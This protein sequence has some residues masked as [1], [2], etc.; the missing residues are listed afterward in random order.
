MRVLL[1]S[2]R[3]ANPGGTERYLDTLATTLR[4]GGDEVRILAG[5]PAGV[6][7]PRRPGTVASL[8]VPDVTVADPPPL[9]LRALT[10]V[11]N[12]AALRAIGAMLADFRPAAVHVA[13]LLSH[14]SPAILQPLRGTATSVIAT[15]LRFACPLGTKLLPDGRQCRRPAGAAC[16][17]DGCLSP[18][19]A[20]RDG[21][22]QALLRSGLH[23]VRGMLACSNHLVAEL[24]TVGIDSRVVPLPVAAPR[25]APRRVPSRAPSFVFAGR[26]AAVKGLDQLIDAFADLQSTSPDARLL[27][28]G[29]GPERNRLRERIRRLRLADAVRMA[30]EMALDWSDSLV[31]ATALVA[32]SLYREPLGLSVIEA[33]L[34]GTP[35]IASRL[36]GHGE[37]VE[38]GVSGLLVDN[39]DPR[40][41]AAA[42]RGLCGESPAVPP[43]VPED[44]RGRL[45]RRH[46]PVHHRET[47]REIWAGKG[48][49][50]R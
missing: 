36:G 28:C 23:R 7:P 31:T 4:A 48:G 10:Q 33:I 30:P 39:R 37:S 46:D 6:L 43:I 9:P 19:R 42:M 8:A 24:A 11:V 25:P 3:G 29:D 5:V 17:E 15:D 13:M 16:L 26:L 35:V 21:V 47:L 34:G 18:V 40:A 12:P 14:L 44:A 27:I 1:V 2:D 41:L 20:L 22:R 50:G 38:D 32:P 45:A 49:S